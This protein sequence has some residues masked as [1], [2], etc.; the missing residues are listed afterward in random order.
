MISFIVAMSNNSVI[1]K[2]NTL[3]WHLPNDLKHFKTITE[4]NTIV[5]GRKTFESLGRV[6]PNRHHIVLTKGD[7]IQES[8]T[9]SVV[10]SIRELKNVLDGLDFDGKEVFIIGGGELFKEF[11]PYVDK[12]YA[13]VINEYFKGDT[14]FP[15]IEKKDWDVTSYQKGKKDDKNNYDYYF[16]EYERKK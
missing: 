14:F 13:T 16:I 1:G 10:P 8:D 7:T 4:G 6:L 9:V 5:M 12:I 11:M 15:P 3:P 2:D